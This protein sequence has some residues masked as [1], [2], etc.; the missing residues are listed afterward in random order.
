[1]P[2]NGIHNYKSATPMTNSFRSQENLL[3]PQ[4]VFRFH[5]FF[6]STY[7]SNLSIFNVIHSGANNL[8]T[9]TKNSRR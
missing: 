9:E 3:H 7:V 1:M 4:I 5:L 8:H 2:I 6:F